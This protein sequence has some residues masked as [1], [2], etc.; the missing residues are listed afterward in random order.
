MT[1]ES[2]DAEAHVSGGTL[3]AEIPL[4]EAAAGGAVAH[5]S[6]AVAVV[7]ELCQGLTQDGREQRVPALEDVLLN[8][9][10]Q[11]RIVYGSRGETG[12]VAAAR[13]LHVLLASSDVPVQL[14]LF[15]SQSTAPDTHASIG[16]FAAA[17]A[18]FGRAD[19]AELI[20]AVYQRCASRPPGSQPLAVPR[21]LPLDPV[22]P[23]K[24]P[25]ATQRRRRPGAGK[26]TG[27]IA[28]GLLLVAAGA[29]AWVWTSD[30]DGDP[31]DV[32]TQ[33]VD[34]VTGAFADFRT[35]ARELMGQP[36]IVPRD[37]PAAGGGTSSPSGSAAGP[38][39]AGSTTPGGT[40]V[41][42]RA[43]AV[44]APTPRQTAPPLTPAAP[45]STLA[46][47]A[48]ETPA[49]PTAGESR[50]AVESPATSLVPATGALVDAGVIYSQDDADVVPPS[51]VLPQLPMPLV[52]VEH[53]APTVNSME[54]LVSADGSVERVRL[55]DGPRRM[56]DMMLLSGAKTWKFEPAR[57]DGVP[58]RYRTV[59]SWTVTP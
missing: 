58:V 10:G 8:A 26:R 54:L 34:A 12:P 24:D 5:W 23:R 43:P 33:A 2:F 14:R 39:A 29:G 27:W 59:L 56:P 50:P 42:S 37:A 22:A 41:A 1:L 36:R 25:Q 49:L 40:S 55:V 38:T 17:L 3:R 31:A 45:S 57:K 11:L 20:Q 30:P 32:A 35:T 46:R 47:A 16:E 52:T 15:L 21:P 48:L 19:R 4:S 7:E 18:Y 51:L 53:R 13:L 6:E 44:P 9:G 28:A